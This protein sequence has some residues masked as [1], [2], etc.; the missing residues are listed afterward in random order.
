MKSVCTLGRGD[1]KQ[2]QTQQHSNMDY[3]EKYEWYT[4]HPLRY[5]FHGQQGLQVELLATVEL[6]QL[7][8]GRGEGGREGG[9]R[10]ERV[11]GGAVF[12]LLL[13]LRC[14]LGVRVALEQ[15]AVEED[16]VHDGLLGEKQPGLS[17]SLQVEQLKLRRPLRRLLGRPL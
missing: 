6:Q 4:W 14:I 17:L 8:Q 3:D 13:L 9:E 7:E 5:F 15:L 10:R 12:L 16:P 1:W 11:L 2:T